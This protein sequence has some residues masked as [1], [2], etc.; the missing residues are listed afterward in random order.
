M[1]NIVES[2]TLTINIITYFKDLYSGYFS[3]S[4]FKEL[5]ENKKLFVN[6]YS[7]IEY[8]KNYKKKV[9]DKLFGG[10]NGMLMRFDT[11][12]QF[13]EE[14]SIPIK[15]FIHPSPSG[16]LLCNKKVKEFSKNS[17]FTIICSRYDG[18]D[19]RIQRYFNIEEISIGDY[20]LYDG[21]TA[22]LVLI[23]AIT[24]EKF[25]KIEAKV[26][27][28]FSICN[29]GMLESDMYTKPREFMNLKVPEVLVN[30]NFQLINKWRM[31]SAFIKTNKNRP[32]IIIKNEKNKNFKDITR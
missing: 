15:N 32:D 13:I 12:Y 24:R 31:N 14:Y 25:V 11:V 6:I 7:L 29:F 9:D 5:I 18:M 16:K 27:E 17:S 28:T 8:S 4:F 23:N 22:A 20:I 30:G 2:K 26:N 1:K 21:D 3:H 10:G 19:C